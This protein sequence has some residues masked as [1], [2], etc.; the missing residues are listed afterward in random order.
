MADFAANGKKIGLRIL[1]L[2]K[3]NLFYLIRA[4]ITDFMFALQSQRVDALLFT[5]VTVFYH[6][7]FLA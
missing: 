4:A 6:Q 1:C 2:N 7:N 3:F 5:I